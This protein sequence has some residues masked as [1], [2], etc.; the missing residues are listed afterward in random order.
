M[1]AGIAQVAATAGFGVDL[2][3][4]QQGALDQARERI[5]GSLKRLELSGKLSDAPE[6]ILD[7]IAFTLDLEDAAGRADLVIEAIIEALEP[8]QALFAKLGEWC[9]DDVVLSSNTSQFRIGQIAERCASPERVIGM[10]WSNP[11]PLMMLVEI[12]VSSLTT[13]EVLSAT[14]DFV[15]AC[16][17]SSV[18][19]R[20][21][22]PG[23]ISNRMSAV[24]FMEAARLVDEGIASPADIDAV[25]RLM[26]G[27]KMGPITTLDLAGLDT[28]LLTTTALS[29]HY[30]GDRFTPP[31]YL[32]E[33]V[34]QG[35][36]GRKSGAGFYDYPGA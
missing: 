22:V 28:A 14:V 12:I 15:H 20:K 26:F 34:A 11:P 32:K 19:C 36:L 31:G 8:K 13:D 24:L 35:R 23:F 29:E 9:S 16:N 5:L 7:R 25:A 4:S 33:L 30:G 6:A 3:D 1:G 27:H 18:V 10:H 21:D 2:V 17:R